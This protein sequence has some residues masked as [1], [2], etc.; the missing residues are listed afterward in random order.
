MPITEDQLR[1][2]AGGGG[3]V[4]TTAGNKL[5][6]IGQ[7]YRDDQTG[8]PNFVTAKTGL[9]GTSE[10]F[11]PVHG[12]DIRSIDIVVD[13]DKDTPASNAPRWRRRPCQCSGLG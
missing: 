13:F 3:N 9:F 10:S 12:A 11:V 8:E 5:G 4:V 6:G 2:V 7:I 1:S